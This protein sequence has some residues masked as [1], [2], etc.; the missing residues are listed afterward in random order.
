[1][2]RGDLQGLTFCNR[3]RH[4]ISAFFSL[5]EGLHLLVLKDGLHPLTLYALK[6]FTVLDYYAG[7]ICTTSNF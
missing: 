6:R 7:G 1:M 5:K 4:D 2:L 3:K